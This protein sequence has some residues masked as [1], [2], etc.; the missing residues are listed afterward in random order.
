MTTALATLEQSQTAGEMRS[1]VN[2][3]Q[4]VMK[5]VMQNGQHY[6]VIPGCGNKPTLLK[7]GAEKLMMTFR[8]AV[9]PDVDDL[10]DAQVRRY[11]VRTRVTSQAT[12]VFLGAGI[13]EC[14]SEEE[15]YAWREAVCREEYE[16]T[17]P[18]L[19]REKWKKGYK[20]PIY[21]VHTTPADVANTIL[22]MAKKRSLIDAILTVT[23]ASDIFTQDLED[24]PEELRD[25]KPVSKKAPAAAVSS[26]P[27]VPNYGPDAGKP[28]TQ[29]STEHLQDYLAGVRRS[30]DD[31]KKERFL[32]KNQEM[33]QLIE[34][35]L[36]A[37]LGPTVASE[38][39]PDAVA[40]ESASSLPDATPALQGDDAAPYLVKVGRQKNEPVQALTDENLAWVLNYYQTKLQQQPESRYRD[41]WEEAILALQAEKDARRGYE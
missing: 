19:R 15:K 35:E 26:G 41:E 39:V 1:Q 34:A 17:D 33:A 24:L 22:K 7:P 31:P 21:Q 11:R 18:L 6:G 32:L 29:V 16:A 9:D 27:C 5:E 13:G 12:G 40:V 25:D 3:I 30:I 10:S 38:R 4:E 36:S 8:L 28:I 14:S 2:R 20:E 37:R 23:A